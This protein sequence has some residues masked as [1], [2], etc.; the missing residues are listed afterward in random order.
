MS[1]EHVNLEH[2][3]AEYNVH[4]ALFRNVRNA[5]FLHQQLL[6]RNTDFE[7]AF[8][9]ASV[10]SALIPS[11]HRSDF[12][13]P[14]DGLEHASKRPRVA[15]YWTIL[16]TVS[17]GDITASCPLRCLQ[18]YATSGQGRSQDPQCPLRNSVIPEP[19][20]QRKFV[21]FCQAWS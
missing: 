21:V 19:F 15:A 2:L 13:G 4:I 17:S 5:S 14:S 16:T 11:S 10:V 8:I 20:K 12:L 3:P 7:Y 1:L 9:D 18:G 6:G